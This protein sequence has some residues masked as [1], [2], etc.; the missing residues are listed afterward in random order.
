LFT[1]GRQLRHYFVSNNDLHENYSHFWGPDTPPIPL[2]AIIEGTTYTGPLWL[3]NP[4]GHFTAGCGGTTVFMKVVLQVV[5]IPVKKHTVS[6]Q[7]R[8]PVFP[9]AGVAMTHGDDPY[10]WSGLVSPHPLTPT[11]LGSDYFVSLAEHAQLFP[12]GQDWFACEHNVGIQVK[13]VAIAFGSD[14]LMDL[15]CQDVAANATHAS[16]KV[17][18]FLQYSYPLLT[19]EN[20]GLWVTLA[21]KAGAT[22]W[23]QP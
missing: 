3:P 23:C 5:N 21:N 2:P 9:T 17:Y 16:G 10:D 1:W 6:C 8:T 14:Y 7:H 4:F 22:G 20:M 13:N 19:L 12:P 18:G 11:P 15:Y